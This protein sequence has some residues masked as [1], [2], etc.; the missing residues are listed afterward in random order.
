MIVHL[1]RQNARSVPW[2][3]KEALAP[4]GEQNSTGHDIGPR[5]SKSSS[6]SEEPGSKILRGYCGAKGFGDFS[7]FHIKPK[8]HAEEEEMP[9]DE[10]MEPD[11]QDILLRTT[12]SSADQNQGRGKC[13]VARGSPLEHPKGI[14]KPNGPTIGV[15]WRTNSRR[16]CHLRIKCLQ[17]TVWL[18]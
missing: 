2:A 11:C 13:H 15:W 14:S 4:I 8:A 12:L 6:P 5:T 16:G 9:E 7:P 1:V 3:S 18:H 17:L 10:Q